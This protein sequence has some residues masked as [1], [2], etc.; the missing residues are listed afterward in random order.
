MKTTR[1]IHGPAAA[2]QADIIEEQQRLYDHACE[3][4]R[5]REELLETLHQHN[6][7]SAEYDSLDG[8]AYL[9]FERWRATPVC[10][11]CGREGRSATN[12]DKLCL[13]CRED[14]CSECEN[15]RKDCEGGI[16]KNGAFT[17]ADCLHELGQI[18]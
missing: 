7:L 11:Q 5:T 10:T 12:P 14:R 9:E 16:W 6:A 13:T 2:R 3:P 18:A 1:Q 8:A 17:C 15:L 4:G